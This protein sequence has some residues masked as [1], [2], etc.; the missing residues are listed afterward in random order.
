[1]KHLILSILLSISVLSGVS[2]QST[3][4]CNSS[5]STY[6]FKQKSREVSESRTE[7][8]R[9][10]RAKQLIQNYC[11]TSEQVKEIAVFFLNDYDRLVFAKA[12]Y[13]KTYD[14]ENFYDVYDSFAYFSTVFRLHDYV[15]Q[16]KGGNT[17]GN[18]GGGGN[19]D[20]GTVTFPNYNYPDASAYNGTKNCSYPLNDGTFMY[21]YKRVAKKEN[22]Q[23][24]LL[25]AV[26]F[27][28]NQC[29]STAQ[30]M[31]LSTVF[32][33]ESNKLNFL[34]QSFDAV[35]D[36]DNIGAAEQVLTQSNYKQEFRSFL[37]S[38]GNT[39]GGGTNYPCQIDEV[40]FKRIKDNIES[41][42]FN[43]TRLNTAKQIL[44]SKGKCFMADQVKELVA[45]FDF[46]SSRLDIAKF[47]YD[48]T[49]DQDNYYVV[50][51]SFKFDSSK[52]QLLEF[53]QSKG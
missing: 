24:R 11:L 30:I 36:R 19:N 8:E 28:N 38:Q 20:G 47:A 35:Y 51:E 29:L 33:L 37:Q 14:P 53:I 45:L 5:I 1:M 6:L 18:N 12:A 44:R 42:S 2:A 15:N 27:M 31:K 41:Q 4:R 10:N 39:G 22:D 34:K 52:N 26:R 23:A 3:T 48:Y 40:E 49:L 21:N 43:N 16:M 9:L 25:S 17:G 50:N 13:P 7:S 32:T 46:E